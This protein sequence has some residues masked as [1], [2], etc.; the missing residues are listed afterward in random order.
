MGMTAKA[1][2]LS[3]AMLISFAIPAAA[4]HSFAMFNRDKT[5]EMQGTVKDFQWTNP[6]SFLD[7]YVADPKGEAPV[8]WTLEFG[9]VHNLANQGWKPKMLVPGDKVLFT[10]HPAKNGGPYGQA[11]SVTLPNGTVMQAVQGLLPADLASPGPNP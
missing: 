4:H 8:L 1:C 9:A 6:H 7:V 2:C 3:A 5:V 10:L 11:L